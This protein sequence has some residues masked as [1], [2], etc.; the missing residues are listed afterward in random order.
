ML[1]RSVYSISLNSFKHEKNNSHVVLFRMEGEY[2]YTFYIYY[3]NE[4]KIM[5]IGEWGV[6]V[7]Y[8]K[9]NCEFC[10]YSIEDIQIHQRN[11]N[12]EF[13]FLTDARFFVEGDHYEDW[14]T[15]D[16][17]ELKVAFNITDGTIRK[18]K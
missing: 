9:Y 8:D 6:A 16:A 3:I 17:G 11:D 18:I 10:D 5:K 15:F 13:L 4:G 12:I 14:G 2:I 1:F 7:P